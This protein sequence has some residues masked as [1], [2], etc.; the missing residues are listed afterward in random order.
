MRKTINFWPIEGRPQ[1]QRCMERS[2]AASSDRNAHAGKK[3][4]VA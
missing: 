4:D 1:A 3:V 2:L